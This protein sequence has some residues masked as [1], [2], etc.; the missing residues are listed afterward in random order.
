[1]LA[2]E[3]KHFAQ[4][5]YGVKDDAQRRWQWDRLAAQRKSRFEVGHFTGSH[6]EN[7]LVTLAKETDNDEFQRAKA[8]WTTEQAE[9][10]ARKEARRAAREVAARAHTDPSA[11]DTPA[12]EPNRRACSLNM[13]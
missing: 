9:F 3:V 1:M 11:P 4:Q 2:Y 7:V 6:L 8:A 13:R 12:Q 10:R 5:M